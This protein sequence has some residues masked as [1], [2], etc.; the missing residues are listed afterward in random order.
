MIAL[1]IPR[2]AKQSFC[3]CSN[4]EVHIK[5]KFSQLVDVSQLPS[6]DWESI[7]VP[8]PE[9]VLDLPINHKKS[10]LNR[11]LCLIIKNFPKDQQE[12]EDVIR[13]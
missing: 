5:R 9:G 8:L 10:L 3:P 12:E 1:A 4:D 11:M 6:D 2:I 7:V 13:M